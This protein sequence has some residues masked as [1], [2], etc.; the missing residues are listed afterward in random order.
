MLFMRANGLGVISVLTVLGYKKHDYVSLRT[1]PSP[2]VLSHK[3]YI[4]RCYKV[5]SVVAY[6]DIY[7]RWN[8]PRNSRHLLPLLPISL[9]IESELVAQHDVYA[10]I[11][12]LAKCCKNSAL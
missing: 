8:N 11:D 6:A 10:L 1:D 12:D 5:F 9:R 7:L 2:V 4:T 3:R